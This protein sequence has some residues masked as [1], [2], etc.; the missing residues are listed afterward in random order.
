MPCVTSWHWGQ[1]RSA[2]CVLALIPGEGGTACLAGSA[3]LS[4]RAFWKGGHPHQG[5][6]V[7][8]AGSAGGSQQ[9]PTL[10]ARPRLSPLQ[11][12]SFNPPC[13]RGSSARWCAPGHRPAKGAARAQ[14]GPRCSD[15]AGQC[16]M[17]DA[18]WGGLGAEGGTGDRWATST[19]CWGQEGQGPQ[20]AQ[21]QAGSSLGGE[22]QGQQLCRRTAGAPRWCGSHGRPRTS[23]VMPGQEVTWV[24]LRVVVGGVGNG[25]GA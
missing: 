19:P 23:R 12:S 4:L 3:W 13:P 10:G 24:S 18:V 2:L 16:G 25:C 9:P 15:P 8:R 6:K 7:R 22:S 21:G 5:A 20:G 1:M 11:M 14:V 17:L